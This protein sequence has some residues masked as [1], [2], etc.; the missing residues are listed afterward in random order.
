MQIN[1]IKR[2]INQFTAL[3][4]RVDVQ[5]LNHVFAMYMY[6]MYMSCSMCAKTLLSFYVYEQRLY[7][8]FAVYVITMHV[9]QYDKAKNRLIYCFTWMCKCTKTESC[10]RNICIFIV[11]ELN[12][13][14]KRCYCSVY[15]CTACK[16]IWKCEKLI[17]LLHHICL[18]MRKSWVMSS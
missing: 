1:L 17:D 11:Y 8:V 12:M 5:K 14:I 4:R 15:D 18:Y 10:L 13:W 9:H 7:H 16:S 3:H 2:K 6:V